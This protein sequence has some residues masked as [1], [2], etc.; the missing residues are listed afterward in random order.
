MCAFD[1]KRYLLEDGI[2]SL[3][4]GHHDIPTQ[5]EDVVDEAE[6]GEVL[7]PGEARDRGM[8][9]PIRQPPPDPTLVNP[10][11]PRCLWQQRREQRVRDAREEVREQLAFADDDED[12]EDDDEDD[13]DEEEDDSDDDGPTHNNPFI[14]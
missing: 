4:Y 8:R 3:A 2:H 11:R 7:R 10:N 6:D 9:V 14:L 12:D 5:V 13:D 1:D